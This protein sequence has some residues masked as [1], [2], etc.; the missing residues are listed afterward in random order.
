MA[1]TVQV[2][3]DRKITTVP[4]TVQTEVLSVLNVMTSP[5]EVVAIKFNEPPTVCAPRL[6]KLMICNCRG[7]GAITGKKRVCCIAG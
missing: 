3:T 6:V 7:D 4:E 2:P 1:E 5:D